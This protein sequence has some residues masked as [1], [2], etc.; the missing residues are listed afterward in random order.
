[1][2]TLDLLAREALAKISTKYYAGGKANIG[3][4]DDTCVPSM[5][6]LRLIV[7]GM[8]KNLVKPRSN[9][10]YHVIAGPEFYFDMISDPTVQAYMSINQTTK[11]MYDNGQLVPMFNMEFYETLVCPCSG[12]WLDGTT[13]KLLTYS[14]TGDSFQS[15]TDDSA[16][17]EH[18]A[19]V[20]SGYL[21]DA[22]AGTLTT[23]FSPAD[24]SYVPNQLVWTPDYNS[25]DYVEFKVMHVYV[26]GKDAL[27]RT[28]LAGEGQA[29]MY[30]KAKGSAGV[31][32][33]IDQ[34]QSIGFKIN[35]VGFAGIRSESVVDYVCVPT[36]LN[37]I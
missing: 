10:R 30:V 23:P 13:K 19:K 36:Q 11:T 8:K 12:E 7:L 27:Y 21:N 4:M 26:L 15:V 6:D 9:G 24:K 1:M 25:T 28:G 37:N 18:Y 32:D 29:K 17:T 3:A 33:P 31:L 20:I 2:E 34:R 35:S 16:S 14:A 5:T 22:V